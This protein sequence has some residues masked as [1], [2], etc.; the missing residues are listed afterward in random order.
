MRR[1]RCG[2][3]DSDF[4]FFKQRDI[5]AYLGVQTEDV[6]ILVAAKD[7]KDRSIFSMGDIAPGQKHT[8]QEKKDGD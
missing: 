4:V 3:C 8:C 1:E 2:A 5:A 7:E 6:T